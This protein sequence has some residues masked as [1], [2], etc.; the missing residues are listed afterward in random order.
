MDWKKIGSA[1]LSNNIV[2]LMFIGLA[3]I[4]YMRFAP[5]SL[6]PWTSAEQPAAQPSEPKEIHTIERI[7]VPGPE[8]IRTIEKVKYTEKIPGVLT[9]ATMAD[10]TAHVIASAKI[11][12][13]PAGGIATGIL[14]YGP[15]NVATGSIEWKPATPP[16]FAIQ[17][18]FGV[19]AGMGTG[20]LVVGEL[21]GRPARVGPVTLEVRAFGKRDDRSGA[22]FGGAVLGDMRF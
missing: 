13:S 14:R 19:R 5:D 6:K 22:D 8:R 16:F 10:N 21:Y 20:G 18:E 15:D 2:L 9:P 7:Y 1:A 4:A 12:P 17:K 11:P 3:A